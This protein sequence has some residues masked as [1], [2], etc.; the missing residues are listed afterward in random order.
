[1]KNPLQQSVSLFIQPKQESRLAG[2]HVLLELGP[3]LLAVALL[4]VA[5]D[6]LGLSFLSSLSRAGK[7]LDLDQLERG[8]QWRRVA[9]TV[10]SAKALVEHKRRS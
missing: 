2:E 3:L 5:R 7:P 8:E 10:I 6:G 1:M 9:P 4:E